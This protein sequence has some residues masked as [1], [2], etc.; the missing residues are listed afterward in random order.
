MQRRPF[1]AR[2]AGAL[3][4]PLLGV[5]RSSRVATAHIAALEERDGGRLGV[6][7]IDTADRRRITHRETERF[8]MCS[9]FKLLAVAA[10]LARVDGGREQLDRRISFSKRDLL[11]YAPVTTAHVHEGSMTVASLC[12]AAI[13]WSDNT[14]AN[15][16][17]TSI[18]GPAQVTPYARSIGYS[19]TRL[20]RNEPSLNS[21]IPGDVRDTTTPE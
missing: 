7:A 6:F 10:V 9:T 17:L 4:V 14:A 21:A 16:L 19:V 11:E 8:P 3:L 5:A 1:I 13:E 12:A 20:A 18:G 2:A 15:L